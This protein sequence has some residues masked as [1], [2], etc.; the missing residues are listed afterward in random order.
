MDRKQLG[1]YGEDLA[2]FYLKNRGYQILERNW[3]CRLG[4]I[5]I[6]AQDAG[7]I[8][9]VEVKMRSDSEYG[10][11]QLAVSF[12]KQRQIVKI[13]I[14]YIKERNL[15]NR[16][17]RFDVLAIGPDSCELLKNAFSATREYVF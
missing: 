4:E 8:V 15:K 9:F 17:L 3:H 12:R 11:P 13:A 2:A 10:P 7:T 1:N 16:D 5:D 14:C 6:I